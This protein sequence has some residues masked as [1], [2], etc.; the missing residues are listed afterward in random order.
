MILQ[1]K[2]VDK[3]QPQVHAGNAALCTEAD[4]K[5]EKL[6]SFLF[7]C[8]LMC[9][10]VEGKMSKAMKNMLNT[11]KDMLVEDRNIKYSKE[12]KDENEQNMRKLKVKSF[13]ELRHIFYPKYNANQKESNYQNPP[14]KCS[15]TEQLW[16]S[17]MLLILQFTTYDV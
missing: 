1:V 6:F 14:L 13:T 17:Y 2:V 10:G 3:K 5:M 8:V 4:I 11:E 15:N 16:V 9:S 12:T 7:F